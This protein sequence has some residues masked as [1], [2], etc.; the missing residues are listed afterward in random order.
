MRI[1]PVLIVVAAC[2]SGASNTLGGKDHDPWK[3]LS[4]IPWAQTYFFTERNLNCFSGKIT[5]VSPEAAVVLGPKNAEITIERQNLL[6]VGGPD[7]PIFAIYSGRS[8]WA[9]VKHLFQNDRHEIVTVSLTT[10]DGKR[11]KG[12]LA[13]VTDA[14]INL[15]K[16]TGQIRLAK[17]RISQLSYIRDKPWS[18]GHEY[19]ARELFVFEIFDPALWYSPK[20]RV[21]LYE[22]SL[23]EDNSSTVCTNRL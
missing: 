23:P 18:E 13:N 10:H 7:F 8:S 20:I 5:R 12:K 16:G 21:R 2:M 11:Y 15:G 1:T 22:S 14:Q 4:Q 19:L 6:W 3:N 17:D 9:D